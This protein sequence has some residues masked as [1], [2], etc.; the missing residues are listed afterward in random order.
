MKANK[1][2]IAMGMSS[3]LLCGSVF[4]SPGIVTPQT[5]TVTFNGSIV[6]ATCSI[7][8]N[9]QDLIVQMG[10][11]ATKD[12]VHGLEA[13][14]SAQDFTIKL[15]DCVDTGNQDAVTITFSGARADEDDELL[16]FIGADHPLAGEAKGAGIKIYAKNT[17]KGE[18]AIKLGAATSPFDLTQTKSTSGDAELNFKAVLKGYNDQSQVP[19][20]AGTFKAVVHFTLNYQ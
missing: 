19:L 11:V 12:L 17:Q 6:N 9:S 7:D 3:M 10:Q 14:S 1:I 20:Q 15:H 13:A 8:G 2:L 5:G 4:A 18:Q 16:G